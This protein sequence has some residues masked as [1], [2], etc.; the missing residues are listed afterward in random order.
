MGKA[1]LLFPLFIIFVPRS[2]SAEELLPSI[3]QQILT[4]E[5]STS[6]SEIIKDH[7]IERAKAMPGEIVEDIQEVASTMLSAARDTLRPA[8]SKIES[9][10]LGASASKASGRGITDFLLEHWLWFASGLGVLVIWQM[11]RR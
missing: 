3:C 9:R 2:A 1:L 4:P 10:V 6:V 8:A 5:K 11:M 7:F